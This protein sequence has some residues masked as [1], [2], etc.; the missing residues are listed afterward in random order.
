MPRLREVRPR[1]KAAQ[2]VAVGDRERTFFLELHEPDRG[3][4]LLDGD[5]LAVSEAADAEPGD[6]VV[7]WR[8]EE[9]TSELQ[10]PT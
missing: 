3:D 7:W 5:L 9:H 1:G 8:S 10:S 4:G 2:F 6:L